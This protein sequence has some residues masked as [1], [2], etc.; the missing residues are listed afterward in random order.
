MQLAIDRLRPDQGV[1]AKQNLAVQWGK[2]V[3]ADLHTLAAAIG[4]GAGSSSTVWANYGGYSGDDNGWSGNKVRCSV[5]PDGTLGTIVLDEWDD[6]GVWDDAGTWDNFASDFTYHTTVYDLGNIYAA[7]AVLELVGSFGAQPVI[8]AEFSLDGVAWTPWP[9]SQND[10]I[11]YL[12]DTMFRYARFTFAVLQDHISEQR[13]ISGYTLAVWGGQ[14]GETHNLVIPVNG[15]DVVYERVYPK[16]PGAAFNPYFQAN[17][18]VKCHVSNLTATGCHIQL[19]L[20]DAT[21]TPINGAGLL[22]A[23]F[24]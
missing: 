13:Y 4:G 6:A 23:V 17:Q 22:Q 10:L 18:E 20:N 9:G 16:A 15:L 7:R 2:A 5:N 8:S 1:V 21:N 14:Y 19:Y 12:D 11:L 24:A 3:E